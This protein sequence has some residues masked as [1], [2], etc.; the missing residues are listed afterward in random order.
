MLGMR[1]SKG[2]SQKEYH[3][4]YKCDFEPMEEL[5]REFEKKGW[6]VSAKGRWRFT[7]AGFLLSNLLIGLMLEKQAELKRSGNPWTDRAESV[8]G[9]TQLPEGEEVFYR[10]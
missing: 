7:A 6:A 10:S 8:V 1:T 5:L 3:K 4:I 2:I 9:D